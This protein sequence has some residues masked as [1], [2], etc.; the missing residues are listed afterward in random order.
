M[1][2]VCDPSERHQDP[3]PRRSTK[4]QTLSLEIISSRVIVSPTGQIYPQAAVFP[5]FAGMKRIWSDASVAVIN[6]LE[7]LQ[8]S[9]R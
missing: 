9:V 3:R 6:R 1:H 2:H 7:R 8:V 4:P 5:T